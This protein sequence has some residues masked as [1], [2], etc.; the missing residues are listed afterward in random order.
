MLGAL[1]MV[2]ALL[3]STVPVAASMARPAA[4]W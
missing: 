2:V 3:A 1:L 4:L